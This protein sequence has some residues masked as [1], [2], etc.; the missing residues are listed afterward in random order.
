MP[1]NPMISVILKL[2]G[3]VITMGHELLVVAPEV[4]LY[5]GPPPTIW[6]FVILYIT[7]ML[8]SYVAFRPY[9]TQLFLI[10]VI[11]LYI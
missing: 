11:I 4:Y 5:Q 3:N 9:L 7:M 2:I 6:H 1:E 8:S 10:I